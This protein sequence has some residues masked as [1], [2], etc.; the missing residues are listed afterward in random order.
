[1]KEKD[2][3]VNV[4]L[5]VIKTIF[6]M[7]FPLITFPYISRTLQVD[8]IGKVNF[9]MSL[10]SY[11]ILI[12]GLGISTYAIREGSR[13]RD[14]KEELNKFVNQIFTINVVSTLISYTLL[15]IFILIVPKL[16]PYSIIIFI[17][18]INMLGNLIGID[19]IYSIYE[20]YL[21]ITIRTI[22]FQF[23]SLIF[24]FLFINE[25]NDYINYAWILVISNLG[26]S[27]LNY[28][29]SRRYIK[30]KITIRTNLKKHIKHI[31][32]IFASTI[33]TTIYVNSDV[34][35]IGIIDNNYSVGIYSTSVKVYTIFKTFIG[36]IIVVTLPRLSNYIAKQ[37]ST[38]FKKVTNDILRVLLII[39]IPMSIGIFMTS[40]EII[41]ILS[42]RD[43]LE[44]VIPLNIL[45]LSLIFSILGMYYTNAILLPMRF[46]KVILKATIISSIVNILLNLIFIKRWSYNGAAITTLISEIIVFI[47]QYR[48]VK[49]EM[50]IDIKI[51]DI[52]SIIIGCLSI[53]FIC[54]MIDCIEMIFII[55]FIL[56]IIISI[57][58]YIMIMIITKNSIFRDYIIK[59]IANS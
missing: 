40:E 32:V 42:G 24:I 25:K 22:I 56:K 54:H 17:L 28:I 15:I 51:R 58:S 26:P 6:T 5:N 39:L 55:K 37:K 53:F 19:W 35:M 3:K 52:V 23:I 46:E 18:S 43:Y 57:L 12:A 31:L 2:L 30:L 8:N 44:A 9:A 20:D 48:S 45:S 16:Q 21:Y 4:V 36:A 13:L 11:F 14:D 47:I 1:M 33:A 10:V 59:N 7:I 27:I 49:K 29:N 38:E 50:P 41:L 34:T